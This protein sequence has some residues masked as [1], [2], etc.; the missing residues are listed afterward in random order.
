MA[1]VVAKAAPK[2]THHHHTLQLHHFFNEMAL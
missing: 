2:P 1:T